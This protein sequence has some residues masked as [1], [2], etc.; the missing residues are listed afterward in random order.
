MSI[1]RKH[2]IR[3]GVQLEWKEGVDG[4]IIVERKPTRGE[5][6]RELMG[7]GRKFL[8]PGGSAVRDLLRSRRDDD[9]LEQRNADRA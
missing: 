6:A 9:A 4:T 5:L 2:N 8:K 7:A 1:A 3:A